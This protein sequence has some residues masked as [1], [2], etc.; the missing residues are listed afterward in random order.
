MSHSHSDS[1]D[2][3]H[4]ACEKLAVLDSAYTRTQERYQQGLVSKEIYELA[5][6]M[7]LSAEKQ[8]KKLRYQL[9]LET[10]G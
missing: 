2:R 6:T 8:V 5:W 9:S 3:Y 7:K 1:W 4:S 10:S